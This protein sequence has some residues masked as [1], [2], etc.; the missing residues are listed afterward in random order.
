M[1]P[2]QSEAEQTRQ[3]QRARREHEGQRKPPREHPAYAK[4]E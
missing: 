2:A 3:E 1:G 4:P